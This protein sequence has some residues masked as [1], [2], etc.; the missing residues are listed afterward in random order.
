MLPA[1]S[2]SLTFNPQPIM[3]EHTLHRITSSLERIATSLEIIAGQQL[4]LGDTHRAVP[5]TGVPTTPLP[6]AA[7]APPPAPEPPASPSPVVAKVDHDTIRAFG[8]DIIARDGNATAWKKALEATGFS[9]VSSIPPD[10]TAE[11]FATLCERLTQ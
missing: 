8:K 3:I 10:K 11:V 4:S 2:L 6:V 5:C 1:R 7:E 9:N